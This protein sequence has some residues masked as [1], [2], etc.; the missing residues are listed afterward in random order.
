MFVNVSDGALRAAP[1]H[2]GGP[3]IVWIDGSSLLVNP[4]DD[5]LRQ[6]WKLSYPSGAISP[7]TND[8]NRYNGISI[9]ADRNSLVTARTEVSGGL[10]IANGDAS[11]GTDFAQPIA[12]RALA[13]RG[14]IAYGLG[15][16]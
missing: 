12:D 4:W 7:I 16:D 13:S 14:A 10:W 2:T 9:G 1:L 8:L 15:I 3:G 6:L 5:N 11:E